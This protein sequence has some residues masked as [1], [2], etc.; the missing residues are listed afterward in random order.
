METTSEDL[1]FRDEA[2]GSLLKDSGP[3]PCFRDP[4]F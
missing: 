3:L 4:L 2:S 1:G